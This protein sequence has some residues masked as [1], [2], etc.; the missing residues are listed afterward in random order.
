MNERLGL[1]EYSQYILENIPKTIVN[2]NYIES[3]E[4]F[5]NGLLFKMW[6]DYYTSVLE[7]LSLTKHLKLICTFLSIMLDYK[8]DLDLPEDSI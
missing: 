8:P 2:Q 5:F 7:P 4:E 3:N 6:E 1:E